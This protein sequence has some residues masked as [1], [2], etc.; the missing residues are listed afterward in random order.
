MMQAHKRPYISFRTGKLCWIELS[1]S[2]MVSWVNYT[3]VGQQRVHSRK[4][5]EDFPYFNFASVEGSDSAD[6]ET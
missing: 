3:N 1:F 2:E 4:E 6:L 5:H